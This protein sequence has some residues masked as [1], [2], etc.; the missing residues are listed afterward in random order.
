MKQF[1]SIEKRDTGILYTMAVLPELSS[2]HSAT[3]QRE[4]K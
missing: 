1:R 2:Q 4:R 3:E